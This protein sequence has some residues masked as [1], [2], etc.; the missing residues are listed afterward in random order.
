MTGPTPR[1]GRSTAAQK[2][3]RHKAPERIGDLRVSYALSPFPGE[4]TPMHHWAAKDANGQV[5]SEI[6][7]DKDTGQ[8][9]QVETAP[10]R[11]REGIAT[12]LFGVA[13]KQVSLYH[14]PAGHRT[15]E[16]HR[17]AKAVGG[18]DIPDHLAYQP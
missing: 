3:A 7:A 16:G 4:S 13:S 15:F 9:M 14:S 2:M 1:E 6:W 10:H 12:A 18:D 8:I 17:W 5:V 11:R